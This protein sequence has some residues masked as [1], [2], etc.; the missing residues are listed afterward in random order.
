MFLTANIVATICLFTEG[1]LAFLA[2]S[3]IEEPCGHAEGEAFPCA[4]QPLY[5]ENF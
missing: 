4:V 5:N 1:I 2:F 3:G